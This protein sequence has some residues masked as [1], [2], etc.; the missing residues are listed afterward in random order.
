MTMGSRATR[1]ELWVE[2]RAGRPAV[3]PVIA[4]LLRRLAIDARPV[5]VRVPELEPLGEVRGRRP[6]LV[7]LKTAT[8]LALSL[9]VA[10]EASGVTFLNPA[11][12]S[13]AA[14]DKA[15]VLALLSAAGVPVPASYLI[16]PGGRSPGEGA[17]PTAA[18]RSGA[19]GWDAT[20]LNGGWVSKP[21]CGWHG[22]GVRFHGTLAAAL[23]EN[24]TARCEQGWLVD[25][26]TRLV[27]RR[28]G[29]GEPDLKVYVAGERMF[30]T[31]KAFT[32]ASFASDEVHPVELDAAQRDI[33]H[34][35]GEALGLR[36]FGVDLRAEAAGQ[37]V[38]DVN[39]FPGFRGFP[40][41]V[42]ALLAEI[43][44][45]SGRSVDH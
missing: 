21:V 9:A 32:E 12:A 19:G 22:A 42:P 28:V 15:A 18:E 37:V 43:D 20:E 16:D 44:R 34:T 40:E 3:N 25:D 4:S 7:L 41:A 24:A 38:I 35:A 45:V 39:P 33:V 2:A 17:D 14:S 29:A 26:G 1:I 6:D 23:A 13:S 8:T 10:D 5:R 31:T 27:Q 36:V 11:A 30:A